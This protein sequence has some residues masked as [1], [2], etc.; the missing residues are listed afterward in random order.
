M[1]DIKKWSRGK[2]FKSYIDNLRIVMSLTVDIDVTKLIEFSKSNNFKFY[3]SMIWIVSKIVNAHDE[4]KYS[5]DSNGNQIKWEYVFPSYTLWNNVSCSPPRQGHALR[6]AL[7]VY[8][9]KQRYLRILAILHQSQLN[10]G[11]PV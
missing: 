6:C 7:W 9:V 11:R 2:L 1:I 8:I 5:W 4:F 10:K 3:P